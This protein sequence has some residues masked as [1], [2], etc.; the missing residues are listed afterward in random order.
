MFIKSDIAGNLLKKY[1]R[2]GAL[3]I[4]AEKEVAI[5]IARFLGKNLS[6]RVSGLYRTIIVIT[7]END[8]KNPAQKSSA[9][10]TKRIKKAAENTADNASYFIP[11]RRATLRKKNIM[12]ARTEDAEKPHTPE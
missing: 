8:S 2:T 10:D 7:T 3:P 11:E 4:S 9:G 12:T 1:R 5:G 6:N